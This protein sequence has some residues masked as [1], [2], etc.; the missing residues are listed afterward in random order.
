[1]S[2]T[3]RRTEVAICFQGVGSGHRTGHLWLNVALCDA[4]LHPK[5]V[6]LQLT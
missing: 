1:M 4:L 3:D 5:T 6:A 2:T